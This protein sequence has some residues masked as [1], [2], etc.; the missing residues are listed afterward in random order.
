[1]EFLHSQS[2]PIAHRDL[3]SPNICLVSLDPNAEV[4]A[5]ILDFGVATQIAAP[6]RLVFRLFLHLQVFFFEDN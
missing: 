2:P 3:R 6:I 5:K 4:N 1:M